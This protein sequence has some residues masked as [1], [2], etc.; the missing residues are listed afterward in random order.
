M[1]VLTKEITIIKEITNS[2]KFLHY[3]VFGKFEF[4]S[5]EKLSFVITNYAVISVSYTEEE[6]GLFAANQN[7]EILDFLDCVILSYSIDYMDLIEFL[8]LKIKKK[9]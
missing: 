2:E 9:G 1:R 7:G 3:L 8:N 6:V 4:Y 5:T